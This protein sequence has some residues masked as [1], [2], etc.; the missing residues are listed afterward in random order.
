MHRCNFAKLLDDE[1][2][3]VS[4]IGDSLGMVIQGLTRRFLLVLMILITIWNA[5]LEPQKSI[6]SCRYAF[7]NLP[8]PQIAYENAVFLMQNG[9][10]MVKLEGGENVAP[11]FIW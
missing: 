8:D 4:L 5:A 9:A 6:N 7:W 1:G 2:I 3:D 10:S 11:N